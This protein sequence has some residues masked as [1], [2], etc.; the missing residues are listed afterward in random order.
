M[1]LKGRDVASA[2]DLQQLIEYSCANTAVAGSIMSSSD[3]EREGSSS[4]GNEAAEEREDVGSPASRPVDRLR[5]GISSGRGGA[6]GKVER[7]FGQGGAAAE[8]KRM[9][10][11]LDQPGGRATHADQQAAR[12]AW[13][14]YVAF[15]QRL[16]PGKFKGPQDCGLWDLRPS[17]SDRRSSPATPSRDDWL[18][19]THFMRV[20]SSSMDAARN[21][22]SRVILY[23][24]RMAMLR[25]ASKRYVSIGH[26]NTPLGLCVCDN[27]LA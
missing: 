12:R 22:V 24:K 9:V 11:L 16:H 6:T 26:P 7:Y 13:Q 5:C 18:A 8:G 10:A 1:K 25:W 27:K 23:G 15:M 14:H 21:N 3:D 4:D 17:S 2:T 19:F 20:G